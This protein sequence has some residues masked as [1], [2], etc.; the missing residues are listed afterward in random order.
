MDRLTASK[1]R[2]DVI[3]QGITIPG[4]NE[5]AGPSTRAGVRRAS[6][7]NPGPTRKAR[8]KPASRYT[9]VPERVTEEQ[10]PKARSETPEPQDPGP[11]PQN[12]QA[13]S[14]GWLQTVILDIQKTVKDIQQKL[15]T[16]DA[17]LIQ[18]RQRSDNLS[19]RV[20]SLQQARMQG[21]TIQEVPTQVSA[22]SS[23]HTPHTTK[24]GGRV[25]EF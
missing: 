21:L 23:G 5:E 20:E 13:Y 14:D 1:K 25:I 10:R 11:P 17:Q 19:L 16:I 18:D 22:P 7:D 2:G 6:E 9:P 15:N 3:H 8:K 24:K 12:Q 4:D